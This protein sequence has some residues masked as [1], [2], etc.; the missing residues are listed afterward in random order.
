MQAGSADAAVLKAETQMR[1]AQFFDAWH[2]VEEFRAVQT[3]GH[4]P[5]ALWTSPAPEWDRLVNQLTNSPVP[6]A[7]SIASGLQTVHQSDIRYRPYFQ[8]QIFESLDHELTGV[9]GEHL[10]ATVTVSVARE[11]GDLFGVY[12]MVTMTRPGSTILPRDSVVEPMRFKRG[13]WMECLEASQ[14]LMESPGALVTAVSCTAGL[15]PPETTLADLQRLD[16]QG[17]LTVYADEVYAPG[18]AIDL[19]SPGASDG[20]SYW[21]SMGNDLEYALSHPALE[22]PTAEA[23]RQFLREAPL[24]SGTWGPFKSLLKSLL[25]RRDM[26]AEA[27]LAIARVT[28]AGRQN[29]SAGGFPSAPSARTLNYLDRRAR[30]VLYKLANRDPQ[31]YATVCLNFLEAVDAGMSEGRELNRR[32]AFDFILFGRPDPAY[33][34]IRFPSSAG[35]V[36]PAQERRDVRPD[37]WDVRADDVRN[38]LATLRNSPEIADWCFQV[39]SDTDASIPFVSPD[40]ALR[41]GIPHLRDLGMRALQDDPRLCVELAGRTVTEALIRDPRAETFRILNACR[42][43]TKDAA[44]RSVLQETGPGQL[45][46]LSLG[47]RI[48]Q[49]SV[50]HWLD[51]LGHEQVMQALRLLIDAEPMVDRSEAMMTLAPHFTVTTYRSWCARNGEPPPIWLQSAA[52]DAAIRSG[53]STY[54][55]EGSAWQMVSSSEPGVP[56]LGWL[57]AVRLSGNNSYLGYFLNSVSPNARGLVGLLSVLI[58]HSLI[59]EIA[60]AIGWGAGSLSDDEWGE[61]TETASIALECHPHVATS[62]YMSEDFVHKPDLRRRLMQIP[63]FAAALT[64]DVKADQI[65]K[66]DETRLELLEGAL[67]EYPSRLRTDAGLLLAVA[68]SRSRAIRSV[69][70]DGLGQNPL[71]PEIW[72]GLIE[73]GLPECVDEG[74]LHLRSIDDLVTVKNAYLALLDSPLSWVRSFGMST[75]SGESAPVGWRDLLPELTEHRDPIIWSQV[76]ARADDSP[77]SSERK[78]F[79]ELVLNT[80]RRGR[81]AKLLVQDHLHAEGTEAS[82][83]PS[84]DVLLSLTGSPSPRDREWA[85]EQLTA[86]AEAGHEVP[87]L[88]LLPEGE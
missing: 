68:T 8:A 54:G 17:V 15:L 53:S 21:R 81:T 11:E 55:A 80:R 66:L 59:A 10:E 9:D 23:L 18:R 13:S 70:M 52:A 57:V 43:E 33:P 19:A 76:A 1:Q 45:P 40:V 24:T 26:P 63:A 27:G 46:P 32:A 75:L 2:I 47:L 41:S 31:A 69:A 64:T 73:S 58:H 84:L 38:L 14:H 85:I 78:L 87:G 65:V 20:L 42:P 56:A 88:Q 5:P 62:L 72:L 37:V 83:Q 79:N 36:H 7:D 16:R 48:A 74:V 34:G 86:R 28:G 3:D 44:I 29:S 30:R 77:S 82:D 4:L 22:T 71:M 67:R 60:T 50:D 51:D 25:D 39:L 12:A 35:L 6:R 49:L 61:T